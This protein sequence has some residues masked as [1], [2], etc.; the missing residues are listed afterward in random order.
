MDLLAFHLGNVNWLAVLVALLP[1]F[2]IGS[3]WYAPQV[4]GNYWMKQVGLKPKDAEKSNML[5]T[6]GVTTVMNFVAVT[7]LAV[8]MSA[9]YFDS[10]AQGAAL[11]ALV[12]LVFSATSRGTH[13][14]F[15]QKKGAGL[16]FLNGIHDALFLTVAGAILGAF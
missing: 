13:L 16:F 14:A 3:V 9:L 2:A 11:G 4:F 6:L 1:S 10:I 15:E 5:Q 7:G 8:L 12:S